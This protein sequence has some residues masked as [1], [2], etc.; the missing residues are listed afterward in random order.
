MPTKK[1]AK[2][3]QRVETQM[4]QLEVKE[5]EVINISN[6]NNACHPQ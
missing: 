4:F 5:N 2:F 3:V 6:S 1:V